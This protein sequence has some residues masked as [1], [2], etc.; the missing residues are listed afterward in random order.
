METTPVKHTL[1]LAGRAGPQE[2]RVDAP[3][4]TPSQPT[5]NKPK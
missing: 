3:V 1:E 2:P 5:S 4:K